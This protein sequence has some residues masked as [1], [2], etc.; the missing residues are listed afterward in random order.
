[1][2]RILPILAFAWIVPGGGHF[3]LSGD[4][5]AQTEKE[6]KRGA[7]FVCLHY[8]VEFPADKGGPQALEW[9]G[10]F[11]KATFLVVAYFL[12]I[13]LRNL[14]TVALNFSPWFD[15]AHIGKIDDAFAWLLAGLVVVFAYSAIGVFFESGTDSAIGFVKSNL[16]LSGT[17]IFFLPLHFQ[18]L[19]PMRRKR[20]HYTVQGIKL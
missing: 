4:H 17:L 2:K 20:I 8:A 14:I 13:V 15:E 6:M 1:M 3:L 10:G 19:L 7:G 16:L 18:R 12:V 5:L 9:M 11:F